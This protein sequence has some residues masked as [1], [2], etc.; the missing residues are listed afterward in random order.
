MEKYTAFGMELGVNEGSGI[1]DAQPIEALVIVKAMRKNGSIFY[2]VVTTEGVDVMLA[3]GMLE[4]A[5]IKMQ[6]RM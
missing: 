3:A 1:K 6:K 4:F 5:R 2:Q